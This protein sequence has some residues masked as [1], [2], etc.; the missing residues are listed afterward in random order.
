MQHERLISNILYALTLIL[1]V[2]PFVAFLTG[3]WITYWKLVTMLGDEQGYVALATLTFILVSPSLGFIMLLSLLSSAWVNVLLKNLLALPRPPPE[4]WKIS[5]E[6]YGFPSG[7]A[8]TSTAFWSSAYLYVRK[9]P[10]AFF[11][12]TL[13]AL[14]SLSRVILGVH[15]PRDVIGGIVIGLAVST[16]T[17]FAS[18]KLLES[19]NK[20][21]ALTLLSYSLFVAILYFIQLDPTLIKTAGVLAGSSLYPLLRE[22]IQLPQSIRYRLFLAGTVLVLALLI[23]YVSKMLPTVVQFFSYFLVAVIIIVSPII[24]YNFK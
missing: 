23:T 22:K 1:I 4:Q 15:Y 19:K 11:G 5:A 16:A 18:I 24:R 2:S 10:L 8:Q 17:Y 20:T 9:N 21:A 12:A 7:H 3:N 14:I 13:V 6:G